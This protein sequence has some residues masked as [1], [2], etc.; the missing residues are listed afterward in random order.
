MTLNYWYDGQIRRYTQHFMRIFAN[1]SYAVGVKADGSLYLRKVPVRYALSNRQVSHLL[2]GV[3]ENIMLSVPMFSVYISDLQYESSMVQDPYHIDK[4]QIYERE[5]DR[6][7]ENYTGE[8]GATYTLKRYM[9]VPYTIRWT[10][11]LWT[12]NNL[13]KDQIIEQILVLFNPSVQLQ[14]TEAPFDWTALTEVYLES[15]TYS[16]RSIPVGT[17][18][19]IDIASMVFRALVWISPPAILDKQKVIHTVITEISEIASFEKAG[20]E[21]GKE[22][23]FSESDLLGRIIT[24]PGNHYIRVNNNEITLLGS[25]KSEYVNASS[26]KVWSWDFLFD[27]YGGYREGIT[28][29]AINLTNDVENENLVVGIVSKIPGV[30]NVINWNPD[31]STL[32]SDTLDPVN[33]L[34][35]PHEEYPGNG[36]PAPTVG[37]RYILLDDLP[38][39]TV[40][41]GSVQAKKWDIIEF[42]NSGWLAVFRSDLEKGRIY[43]LTD[44]STGTQYIW[45]LDH[46][47]PSINK[48]YS[49]GYWKIMI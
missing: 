8:L 18:D 13:Q 2:R 26:N 19:E 48:I 16:S 1:F 28:A 6:D 17:S 22:I 35:N 21:Q 7:S 5:Y 30:E 20:L 38:N 29:I 25:D 23:I 34:I 39:N 33:K 46:W 44:Q 10:V 11:D 4:I 12:S 41:W 15:F 40:A 27:Q 37:T 32:P 45:N 24:T 9:P 3:N 14:F 42:T 43:Y 31:P 47:E 36:L 49:P